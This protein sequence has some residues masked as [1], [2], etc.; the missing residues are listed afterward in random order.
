VNI[1]DLSFTQNIIAEMTP[2][3]VAYG[4]RIT[5]ADHAG[6]GEDP[7]AVVAADQSGRYEN[8]HPIDQAGSQEFP[9]ENGPPFKHDAL[10]IHLT[11]GGQ[12]GG[13]IDAFII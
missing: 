6:P 4:R 3:Q 2:P 7:L 1:F 9:A 10:Q 5:Q 13:G 12:K 8:H 11:K